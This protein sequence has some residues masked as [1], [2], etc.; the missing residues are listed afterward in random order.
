M[1]PFPEE[2][3]QAYPEI[4]TLPK[5]CYEVDLEKPLGIIFEEIDVGKGLFVQDLVAGG[6]AE[7][8]GMVK[9]GD[10]LV[11]ITAV[12]IVGAKFE[13]RLIPCR[14]FD[15]DTMVGAI[16][17]NNP[18]WGCDSVVLML[19]RPDEA[20]SAKVDEFLEFW[21][22]PFDSPCEFMHRVS[23]RESCACIVLEISR[24]SHLTRHRETATMK[25]PKLVLLSNTKIATP[26]KQKKGTVS[27]KYPSSMFIMVTN[28][29]PG[30]KPS[31]FS[32]DGSFK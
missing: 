24:R 1:S 7:R 14:G 27:V 25:S 20:D 11:A 2:D 13:R 16:E 22:P 28:A 10:N 5:G 6:N 8:S 19:E 21:E 26:K 9:V 15:F 29:H 17:S 18:K 23:C 3:K 32:L 31:I 12:K 30:S 4:F